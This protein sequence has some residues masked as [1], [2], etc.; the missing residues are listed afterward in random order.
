[1]PTLPDLPYDY[2]AIDPQISGEIM[3][4]VPR[5]ATAALCLLINLR[6]QRRRYTG[7]PLSDIWSA[8]DPADAARHR[9]AC[10]PDHHSSQPQ[11]SIGG[12]VT[13]PPHR[14]RITKTRDRGC[15]ES[16]LDLHRMVEV[17]SHLVPGRGG[18]GTR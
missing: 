10:V 4:L 3:E 16:R 9:L 17:W 6:S 15:S 12:A 13:S 1:M 18:V 2:R 8:P 11:S 14:R 7:R 5:Q